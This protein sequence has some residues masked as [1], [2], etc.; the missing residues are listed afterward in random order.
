VDVSFIADVGKGIRSEIDLKKINKRHT[1]LKVFN[2]ANGL[3]AAAFFVLFM[4]SYAKSYEGLRNVLWGLY[5]VFSLVYLLLWSG[6]LVFLYMKIKNMA[7]K[8]MPDGKLFFAMAV[9]L[10]SSLAF[11]ALA[12]YLFT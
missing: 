2:Y 4:I 9:L 5:S 12:I 8:I 7:D 10:F 3:L 1:C 11:N 6:V